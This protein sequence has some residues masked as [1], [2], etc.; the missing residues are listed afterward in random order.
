MPIV[1]TAHEIAA[2]AVDDV[3]AAIEEFVAYV[4]DH[5]PGTTMYRAWQQQG[6]PTKFVHLFEFADDEAHRLH[7]ESQAV[8]KFESV[9]QPVLTAGPV[10]FT[11]HVQVAAN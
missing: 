6:D 4:A 3:V 8:R 10:V 2:A 1:Q 5:E 7:G 11:D 9:Y